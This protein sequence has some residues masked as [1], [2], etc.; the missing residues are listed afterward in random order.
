MNSKVLFL[1]G[2]PYQLFNAIILRMTECAGD[3]CDIILRPET[4]WD[5]DM[6]TRLVDSQVFHE[7]ITVDCVDNIVNF[8]YFD[9]EKQ[10]ELVDNPL[11]FFG[12][13]PVEPIYDKIFASVPHV[14]WKLIYRWHIVNGKKPEVCMFDE[15][16]RAYTMDIL[17]TDDAIYYKGE[18]G[19]SPFIS[20]VTTFYLHQPECY[21]ISGYKYEL[22][23]IADPN[24]Y[25]EVKSK[26]VEIYGHDDLPDEP[27]IFIEDY[28][29][30]DRHMTNDLELFLMVADVVGKEN[31]IVKRHPR[32]T[33]DRFTPLGFKTT[34]NAKVPWELQ[35]MTS[36][37]SKKLLISVTSTAV[38]TPYII[39]DSNVHVLS[40]KNLLVGQSLAHLDVGFETFFRKVTK[41]INKEEVFFHMP[42][43]EEE[44]LESVRYFTLVNK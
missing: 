20:G 41:K 3:E 7:M 5:E 44:L 34:E 11:M 15:G 9:N 19:K 13:A 25:P 6:I 33:V 18:Y 16:L 1:V 4:E 37:V 12:K 2:S 32:C 17:K 8:W 21:S 42:N 27:Y 14:A 29:F 40:L 31:I 24:D 23:E 38:L 30:G 10:R 26:L 39:F 43:S 28:Y 36:D 22:K 35:L